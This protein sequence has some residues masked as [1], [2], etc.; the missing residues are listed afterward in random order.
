M[1]GCNV[2]YDRLGHRGASALLG[3]GL[4]CDV[5]SWGCWNDVWWWD[6]G[7][8]GLRCDWRLGKSHDG[9]RH[10]H[11]LILL[12]L[13]IPCITRYERDVMEHGS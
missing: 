2:R 6:V 7:N 8:D 13:Y 12:G 10:L 3:V 5:A 11:V 9:L 1:D 4:S